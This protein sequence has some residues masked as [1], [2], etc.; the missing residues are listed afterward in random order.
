MIGL[1]DIT[2]ISR[3]DNGF[4]T[5]ALRGSWQGVNAYKLA[6]LGIAPNDRIV[7]RIPLDILGDVKIKKN[8]FIALGDVDVSG[9]SEKEIVTALGDSVIRVNSI[10]RYD[11]LSSQTNHLEVSGA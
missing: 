4:T 2:H 8:D 10:S 5:N 9:K 7:V 11:A 6:A 1:K 3:T